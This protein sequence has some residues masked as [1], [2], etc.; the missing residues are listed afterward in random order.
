MRHGALL[1]ALSACLPIGCTTATIS[2]S[3]NLAGG[4]VSTVNGSGAAFGFGGG[5]HNN[6]CAAAIQNARVAC[7][8]QG[9]T[10]GN[11]Q[12]CI[13]VPPSADEAES[14]RLEPIPD[15]EAPRRGSNR[16]SRQ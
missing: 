9:G 7:T 11:C 4:G 16:S 15:S 3:C 10:L 8:A 6:A 13:T 5:A 14:G 1:L 12:S 2:C